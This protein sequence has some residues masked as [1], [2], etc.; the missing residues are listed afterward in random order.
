[1]DNTPENERASQNP[2]Q[3]YGAQPYGAEEMP[4]TR[5]PEPEPTPYYTPGE[6][7][8]TPPASAGPAY[9]SE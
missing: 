3:G 9:G 8:Y 6:Q 5:Y 4:Q 7:S 2:Y 1:M